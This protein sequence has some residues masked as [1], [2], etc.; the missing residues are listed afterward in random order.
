MYPNPFGDPPRGPEQEGEGFVPAAQKI[1]QGLLAEL[2]DTALMLVNKVLADIER[3]QEQSQAEAAGIREKAERQV[4]EVERKSE[5][6]RKTLIGHAIEQLEPLQK[7][8]LRT[9][10][11]GKAL[12]TFVQIQAFR[13]RMENVLPD[14]GNLL[15]F[16]QIG[17]TFH[18]RV[19]GSNQ[20]ALWGTDVYTADSQLASA[21]VHVGAVELGEEAVVRVTMVDMSNMQIRGSFRHGVMSHDWG[22]YQVGYRVSRS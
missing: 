13:A 14:P 5:N 4:E 2:P 20:G 17:K 8:L 6:R 3:M 16:A 21:A 7:D 12:A 18:F 10:E 9:G 1:L 15:N 22:P 11:L 19:I